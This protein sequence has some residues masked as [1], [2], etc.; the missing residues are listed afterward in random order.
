[1]VPVTGGFTGVDVGVVVGAVGLVD[2]GATDGVEVTVEVA[3]CISPVDVVTGALQASSFLRRTSKRNCWISIF[4]SKAVRM[5]FGTLS[6]LPVSLFSRAIP[7][8]TAFK[9]SRI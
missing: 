2:V 5:S 9:A 1:M 3:D 4:S 7:C 8:S 6:S